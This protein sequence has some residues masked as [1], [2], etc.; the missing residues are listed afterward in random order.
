MLTG[1]PGYDAWKTR[2]DRD[3]YPGTEPT[4]EDDGLDG[5]YERERAALDG[6]LEAGNISTAEH[7]AFV[8]ELQ[9]EY[10]EAMREAAQLTRDAEYGR[11]F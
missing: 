7:A 10:G 5:W 4:P 11:R 6:W 8:R 1:I 9:R 3:E 2:S